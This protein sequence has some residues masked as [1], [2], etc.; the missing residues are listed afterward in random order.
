MNRK[1]GLLTI[2]GQPSKCLTCRTL[3]N[4]IENKLYLRLVNAKV[5]ILSSG[6]GG[7]NTLLAHM[8]GSQKQ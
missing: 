5:H 8:D 2:V 7:T 3:Y 6:Q 4:P 1:Q